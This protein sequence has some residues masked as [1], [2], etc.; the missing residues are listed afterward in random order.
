MRETR[1]LFACCTYDEMV[2]CI[3]DCDNNELQQICEQVYANNE[4]GIGEYWCDV[5]HELFPEC[6]FDQLIDNGQ[7]K[8]IDLLREIDT[9][10]V[11][12]H[13]DISISVVQS[14]AEESDEKIE[15]L[16]KV[17]LNIEANDIEFSDGE[18][19][20]N[21]GDLTVTIFEYSESQQAAMP[22]KI[23]GPVRDF[24]NIDDIRKLCEKH[25]WYC[26]G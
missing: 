8:Y 6:L 3:S 4:E 17:A 15:E 9:V 1:I 26:V 7:V 21:I 10:N 22:R 18:I 16:E 13:G 24:K 5:A 25:S 14:K 23:F 11:A 2:I 12:N 19:E 20:I